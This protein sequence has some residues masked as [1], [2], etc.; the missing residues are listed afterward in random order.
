MYQVV[1]ADL[2]ALGGAFLAAGLLARA[3]RRFGL[4][5]I[6]LFMPPGSCSVRTPR[7]ALVEHPEALALLASLGLVILLFHLGV[8]F[9]VDDL[10]S[11]GRTRLIVG[12]SIHAEPRRCRPLGLARG[13]GTREALVLAGIPGISSSAIVTKLLVEL[14]RLSNPESVHDPRHHRRRGSLPYALYLAGL[15]PVLSGSSGGTASR[16]VAVAFGF[17]A[18]LAVVARWGGG[19]VQ[20]LLAA[21]DDELLTILFVGLAI[22]VAGLAAEM[23]VSDAIGAL[24]AGMIVASTVLAKRVERLVR[25]LRDTFAAMF[26]F[27]F[28]L[29]IEPSEVTS[30]A[31]PVA[32]AIA[33]TFVL[34]LLAGIIA[35]RVGRHG[36]IGA[37]N[38]A[39][40]VLARGEFS[41]IL[42]SLAIAGGLDPRL[43][44]FVGLYVLVLALTAPIV[45]VHSAGLAH[46]LPKRPFRADEDVPTAGDP[47]RRS[48]RHGELIVQATDRTGLA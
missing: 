14:R 41:L 19:L 39:S 16:D 28:G 48:A 44:P 47:R 45:A 9:S 43:G 25:P 15:Q 32:I 29:S 20:R 33:L 2:I 3:G 46:V 31:G 1:A 4:P 7:L 13:W 35:A 5:T 23:G 38:I 40:T 10:T 21:P 18:V 30:V 22:F 36:R 34:N 11:G 6:P 8:E 37:A 24:L 27:A 26:F 17:L 12:R 42:A